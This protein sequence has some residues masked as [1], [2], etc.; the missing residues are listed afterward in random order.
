MRKAL[1]ISSVAAL[2][3]AGQAVAQDST[4]AG[5]ISYSYIEADYV[6]ADVDGLSGSNPDGFGVNG[7]LSFTPML[8]GYV[9]YN[10][11]DYS[12]FTVQTWEVGV[13]L[14][15]SLSSMVDLVGRLGYVRAKIED[16]GS[17]DGLGL[18][19][20]LRARPAANFEVEGLVHYVDSDDGGNN[21]SL[22]A[23]ARYFFMPAFSV[24][25][26]I[27]YDDDL[28]L[29]NVGFRYTFAN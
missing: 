7:S 5:E 9:D 21:T 11:L 23:A 25:A 10:N 24:G 19:A 12:G 16:L 1:L 18:Q 20:G 8:H 22:K 15:H 4:D 26:G 17:D 14:N 3:I 27:E 28:T 29:Y 2:G 6:N 13:G